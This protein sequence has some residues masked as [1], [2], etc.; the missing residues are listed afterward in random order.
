M[1]PPT[2]DARRARGETGSPARALFRAAAFALLG[3]ALAACGD[4]QSD[5]TEPAAGAAADRPIDAPVREV[6]EDG[7]PE[8]ALEAKPAIER[9]Y[10]TGAEVEQTEL[11]PESELVAELDNPDPELRADAIWALALDDSDEALEEHRA[12]VIA[13]LAADP[14]ARV[15]V[16]A[17]ERLGEVHTPDNVSALIQ[18]LSDPD[19]DVVLAAIDSLDGSDDPRLPAALEALR[20]SPNEEVRDAAEIALTPLTP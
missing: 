3:I 16:A 4:Q 13:L 11:D 1:V 9:D 20:A 7:Q 6:V 19:S 17:A 18:A 8:R 14:D 15:R 12:R 2:S 5:S 10:A